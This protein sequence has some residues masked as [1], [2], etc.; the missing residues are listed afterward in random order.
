MRPKRTSSTAAEEPTFG[1]LRPEILAVATDA[2][3]KKGYVASS[4][5]D[6]AEQAGVTAAAIYYHY[7][8]KEDLLREIIFDGLDRL[9]RDVVSALPTAANPIE[10]LESVVRAHLRFNVE[11]VRESKIIIE[12]SRFLNEVDYAVVRE[13]Q[14]G[15]LNIYR[16]CILELTK[17]GRIGEVDPTIT[18]FNIVSIVLGWYRWFRPEGRVSAQDAF[19]YTLRFAM[20]AVINVT[21]AKSKAVD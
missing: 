17:S 14:S 18:A 5:R 3:A 15:I 13:K 11:F 6:I 9:S 10:A 4:L 19:D 16:A 7:A 8:K 21:P 20:A 1:V 12:E 2:F